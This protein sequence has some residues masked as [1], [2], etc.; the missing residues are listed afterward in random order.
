MIDRLPIASSFSGFELEK[1]RNGTQSASV[2]F[3]TM[4]QALAMQVLEPIGRH[5][6]NVRATFNDCWPADCGLPTGPCP[7]G[8]TLTAG[9]LRGQTTDTMF[10]GVASR[11]SGDEASTNIP[12]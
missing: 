3:A 4:L 12:A 6:L 10:R 5:A 11:C 9:Q 8:R 2:T 7:V 1:S